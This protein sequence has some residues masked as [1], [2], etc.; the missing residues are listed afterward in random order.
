MRTYV[1]GFLLIPYL[2]AAV[3]AGWLGHQVTGQ[4][5]P[6]VAVAKTA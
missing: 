6:A 1:I 4:N 5:V 3:A 2:L